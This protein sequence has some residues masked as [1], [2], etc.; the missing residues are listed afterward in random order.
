V[1]QVVTLEEAIAEHVETNQT[2]PNRTTMPMCVSV[3]LEDRDYVER[4]GKA[5]V[6]L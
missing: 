3:L 1:V 5:K 6:K 2:K 4:V